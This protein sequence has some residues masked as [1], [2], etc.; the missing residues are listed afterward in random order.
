MNTQD[1]DQPSD[2]PAPLDEGAASDGEFASAPVPLWRRWVA[3]PGA[4]RSLVAS[5]CD[6]G[7]L[8]AA[9]SELAHARSMLADGVHFRRQCAELRGPCSVAGQVDGNITQA[10]GCR[11]RRGD[12]DRRV[13]GDIAAQ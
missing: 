8:P 7:G 10:P 5:A 12:R 6:R 4:A 2:L 9:A 13:K 1:T 11:F 3:T